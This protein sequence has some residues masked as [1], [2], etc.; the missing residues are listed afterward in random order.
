[1]R[2]YTTIYNDKCANERMKQFV[3]SLIC[4][5]SYLH[6]CTFAKR[7]IREARGLLHEHLFNAAVGTFYDVDAACGHGS[8]LAV[9]CV[10]VEHSV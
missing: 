7:I 5:F 3:H 6:I 9:E 1:M 8:A 2:S 4:T 10:A